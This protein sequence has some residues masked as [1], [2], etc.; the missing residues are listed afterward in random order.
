MAIKGLQGIL[1][2]DTGAALANDQV[3]ITAAAQNFVGNAGD[4]GGNNLAI[5]GAT[6]VSSPR[7]P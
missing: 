1:N 6:Y 2:G 7:P 3:M 4:I 5:G